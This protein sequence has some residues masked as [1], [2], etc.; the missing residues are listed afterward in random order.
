[1]YLCDNFFWHFELFLS[2]V[3]FSILS[4]HWFSNAL[5]CYLLNFLWVLFQ[6][7]NEFFLHI[8][9]VVV[10]FDL[11]LVMQIYMNCYHGI[12]T[13]KKCTQIK[14]VRLSYWITIDIVLLLW[15][16]K[17]IHR[18]TFIFLEWPI[19]TI[20]ILSNILKH[21]SYNK[22]FNVKNGRF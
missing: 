1:M 18:F 16:L 14:L 9:V 5:F 13:T 19:W 21:F 15:L 17:L 8:V 11:W 6:P 3:C 20:K 4:G 2:I 22:L 7:L 10:Y 12:S